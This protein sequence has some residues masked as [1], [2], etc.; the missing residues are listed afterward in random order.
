MMKFRKSHM[1]I[2]IQ[3]ADRRERALQLLGLHNTNEI[4][5]FQE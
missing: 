5:G 4:F 1:K 2:L 3:D